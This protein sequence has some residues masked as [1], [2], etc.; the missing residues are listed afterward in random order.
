[1]GNFSSL[2]QQ[3]M[4]VS[5]QIVGLDPALHVVNCARQTSGILGSNSSPEDGQSTNNLLKG[6]GYWSGKKQET[7]KYGVTISGYFICYSS[8][9]FWLKTIKKYGS[10]QL[11]LLAK[12][13][14]TGVLPGVILILPPMEKI[15]LWPR[16]AKLWSNYFCKLR[17]S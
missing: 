15:V 4:D 6:I 8:I 2:R 12:I 16:T 13:F 11:R 3:L 14:S 5:V 9:Q 17:S 10:H 7:V 1:M